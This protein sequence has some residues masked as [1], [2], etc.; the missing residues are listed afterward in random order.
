MG[1]NTGLVVVGEHRRRRCGPTTRPSATRP[2]SPPACEQL[3]E[4]GDDP[5][6]R[7]DRPAGERLRAR[8][9]R[10]APL[11][12]KGKGE[13]VTSLPGARAAGRAARPSRAWAPRAL[14][15]LRRP[16]PPARAPCGAARRGS[17]RAAARWSAWSASPG[18]ASRGCVYEFRRSLAGERVT[19]LEGRCLSFGAAIPY[20][21]CSTSCGRTAGSRDGR[22]RRGRWP[23]RCASALDGGRAWSAEEGRR[24]SS[25]CWACARA[26]RRSRRLSPEAIKARTF[27]TLLPD[28]P[29]RA[30][31]RR[32]LIF[33][34]EDLHWIDRTSE[35]FFALAGREPR[36]ARRSCSSC[37]YRPGYSAAV[38]GPSYATQLSLP[39]LSRPPTRW[40]SCA[41]CSSDDAVADAAGRGHP[42]PRRGQ[43]VLPRGAG[44]GR[45]AST[46]TS[47]PEVAVPE[48]IQDVLMARIDRLPE[49]PRRVLQTASVLG[50]EFPL[51]LLRPI[52]DGTAPA[53][54]APRR[55]EA[56]G[57]PPRAVGADESRSTSSS[58]PSPRTWPTTAC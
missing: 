57:I 22:R 9:A 52:W 56:P 36:R 45:G 55:A 35:E 13:P 38:D 40:P 54:A 25:T 50:R 15:P 39:P 19:Y 18:W 1:L 17:R 11:Q 3:A 51:R 29:Q 44:P 27:E 43:P 16:G 24:T 26:R 30:A 5:D 7:V 14:E 28:E 46:A 21:P 58:T 2:T 33:V 8:R 42:R 53:R 41:R 34:V 31:G 49:E 10:S 47:G 23:R 48:T 37:T 6:Q 4:P 32:P 20:L 12:V